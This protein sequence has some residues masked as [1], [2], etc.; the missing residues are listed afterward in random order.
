MEI[1][2]NMIKKLQNTDDET[3]KAAIKSIAEALGATDKQVNNAVSNVSTIK[4]KM[5][6]MSES[7]IKQQV[8]KQTRKIGEEKANEILR[9][10]KL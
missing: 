4:K 1:D 2:I 10:L 3:L 7:E 6:R 8:E 5:S 9:Q